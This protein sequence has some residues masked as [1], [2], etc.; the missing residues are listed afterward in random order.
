VIPPLAPTFDAA[1]RD[2]R[3]RQPRFREAAAAR[4]AEPPTERIEEAVE[5]LTVLAGDDHGAVR[6]VALESLGEL[7]ATST[8][9][10]VLDAFGDEYPP[11]RQAAVLAYGRLDPDGA[12]SVIAPLLDDARPDVRFSAVWTLSHLGESHAPHLARALSDEDAEV[13]LLAVQCLADLGTR[14]YADDVATLL[15]DAMPDVRFGAAAGLA[16]MGDRR[17]ADQLR[18]SLM[19]PTRGFQ[20]AIGLGD[21]AD[22][23]S[24]EAL[25]RLARHP[26]RSP[27]LRAAAAR[28]LVK[29]GDTRG[30][31]LLRKLVRSWRIEARQ[32]AV[33]LVG[34]LELEDLVP[35]LVKAFR[36]SS[37]RER[38]VYETAFERLSGKSAEARALLASLREA[39]HPGKR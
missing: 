5:G 25:L 19:H 12:E 30:I 3:A 23:G 14:Q 4:L 17:G 9:G 31:E 2:V 13:R 15:E 32:Y 1:L 37:E 26:L 6:A 21:L 16:A 38:A 36:K 34:E 33:Q 29:L 7:G 11:A 35:D 20:A 27:I 28:G 8:R 18:R 10:A 39:A 24:H 22:D